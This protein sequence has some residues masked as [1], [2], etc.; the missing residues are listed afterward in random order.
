MSKDPR[1]SADYLTALLDATVD[2]IVAIRADGV[3]VD[4]NAA[5]LR[6][7]GY[8]RTELIGQN[9]SMLMPDPDRGRHD[10]YIGAY[11]ESGEAKIIG[12]GRDVRGMRSDGSTFPMNLAVG[13]FTLDGAPMFTGIIRDI[14]HTQALREEL[15]HAQ[16]LEAV[17]QLTGGIAHD[18]NNLLAVVQGNL[19]LLE[20]G[21]PEGARIWN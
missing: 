3:M 15:A 17:G 8:D 14:S 13:E 4:V 18:F 20:T 1:T 6:I 5:T 7:F 12:I 19:E 10:G 2:G 11:L 21:V 9:V 16:R